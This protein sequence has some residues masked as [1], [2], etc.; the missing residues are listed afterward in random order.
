M[1]HLS[2]VVGRLIAREKARE[3]VE[4]VHSARDMRV[5]TWAQIRNVQQGGVFLAGAQ[6]LRTAG[7]DGL[8]NTADDGALESR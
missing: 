2:G 1:A 8:V 7:A 4:S 3:A 5:I 6:P